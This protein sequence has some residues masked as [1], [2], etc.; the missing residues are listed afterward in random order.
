MHDKTDTK[1][2]TKDDTNSIETAKQKQMIF[3]LKK[4]TQKDLK[5]YE[6]NPELG[7]DEET[8]MAFVANRKWKLNPIGHT[9][10]IRD[11]IKTDYQEL[12]EI[13]TSQLTH[14]EVIS[15][16]DKI[17]ELT[18]QILQNGLDPTFNYDVEANDID[19]GPFALRLLAQE[20]GHF[21]VV[22]GGKVGARHLQTLQ[23][24]SLAKRL[25]DFDTST[26]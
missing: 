2:I 26:G 17:D 16:I 24:I 20:I 15:N 21:L 3:D 22:R 19:I 10:I 12:I 1:L 5:N 4:K 11:K 6:K 7:I 25:L 23:A 18:K 8:M 13:I 9:K 14:V